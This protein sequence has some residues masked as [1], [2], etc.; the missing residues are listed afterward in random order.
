MGGKPAVHARGISI[1]RGRRGGGDDGGGGSGGKGG[2]SG[3]GGRG[4]GA[5]SGANSVTLH[6]RTDVLM[7]D[8]IS[9][10]ACA[11]RHL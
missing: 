11:S 4:G 7:N 5:G 6:T 9:H 3:G 2:G 1:C 10:D 8:T